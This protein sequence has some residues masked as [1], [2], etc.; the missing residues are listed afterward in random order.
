MNDDKQSEEVN[1]LVWAL[2]PRNYIA[3]HSVIPCSAVPLRPSYHTGIPETVFDLLLNPVNDRLYFAGES[4]NSS[5][6]GYTHAGYGSGAYVA[7][8]IA[9]LLSP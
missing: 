3:T 9:K 2:S 6:Y 4:T 8:Q 5:D 7:H 1:S